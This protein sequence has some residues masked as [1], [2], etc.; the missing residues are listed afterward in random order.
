VERFRVVGSSVFP[1]EELARITEPYTRREL[2]TEELIEVRDAITRHYIAHG[3]IS[4]G[5][6]IPSQTAE[7]GI[8]EIRVIEGRL[9]EISIEGTR[10]FRPGY[11]RDRLEL[12]ARAPL[13]IHALEQRLQL[14]QQDPR[15]RQIHAALEP[16][17]VRGESV[18]TVR[19]EEESPTG[20][21]FYTANDESPSIGSWRGALYAEHRNPTG[22]GDVLAAS[23]GMTSGL[24]EWDLSY[25]LPISARDTILELYLRDSQSEVVEH[26]FDD[27]D[28][29]SE[30]TTW[31]ASLSH[32]FYRTSRAEL[33]AGVAGELR[34]SET[35]LLGERFS[36]S[37]GADDGEWKLSLL[38][39]FQEWT[40]RS[41]SDVFAARSTFNFGL[42]L[43]DAT[44]VHR[45]PSGMSVPDGTFFSWL[46][47]L[48]WARRLPERYRGT[49][50]VFRT[51]LQ[52]TRD[53]LPPIEQFSVGGLRTVRG[54]REN[55][56]VRDNALVSSIELRIPMLRSRLGQ[57]LLQLAPFADFGRAWNEEKTPS[58]KTIASLGVGL[59]LTLSDRV[60]MAAYWGGRLRKVGR[61]GNNLQNNGFHLQAIVTAF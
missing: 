25:S 55:Q 23:F 43:F 4:S 18:L 11:L 27:L 21:R 59:R 49:Q 39:L 8:V 41:R 37:L 52:L 45:D 57:D 35:S 14:F 54:Y 31:G 10:R 47:Q 9:A 16:G 15:F 24:D 40:S 20:L 48:Q 2:S 3:Y 46:G 53:P 1:D 19:A 34:R 7:D 32:P 44:D 12:A 28:I 42:D 51:D 13:N 33:R 26:T 38:R 29:E 30:T 22:R 61:R 36:F 5:A 6:V 50:V 60:S 17:A 58:P 56:L